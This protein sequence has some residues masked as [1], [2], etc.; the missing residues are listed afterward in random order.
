MIEIV[1]IYAELTESEYIRRHVDGGFVIEDP[2]G[3]LN[4]E[5]PIAEDIFSGV[6]EEYQLNANNYTMQL[7]TT[8]EGLNLLTIQEKTT[9]GNNAEGPLRMV[10]EVL[11]R[12]Q[13]R[14]S[15]LAVRHYLQMV[16]ATPTLAAQLLA[17]MRSNRNYNQMRTN[18]AILLTALLMNESEDSL[19]QMISRFAAQNI[20]SNMRANQIK[21]VY[22]ILTDITRIRKPQNVTIEQVPRYDGK[23]T[24]ER[25]TVSRFNVPSGTKRAVH[26]WLAN[27]SESDMDYLWLNYKR[28]LRS[29]VFGTQ[30]PLR[31]NAY[32][33]LQ[34]LVNEEHAEGSLFH[35]LKNFDKLNEDERYEFIIE[36]RIP[37]QVVLSKLSGNLQLTDW[38]ATLAV[39]TPN[40]LRRFH[41]SMERMGIFEV[42][43]LK[44][45]YD[46]R[47]TKTEDRVGLA[48]QMALAEATNNNEVKAS[49]VASV[50]RKVKS[51]AIDGDIVL[52]VDV[53]GSLTQG[54]AA[55]VRIAPVLITQAEAGAGSCTTLVYNTGCA[56]VTGNSMNAFKMNLAAITPRGGTEWTSCWNYMM[57]NGLTPDVVFVITDQG[58]QRHYQ[59]ITRAI[60]M[61]SEMHGYVPVI[62]ILN[63][64]N[65]TNCYETALKNAGLTEDSDYNVM[66][67]HD[68]RNVDMDQVVALASRGNIWQQTHAE[69]EEID[70]SQLM[71]PQHY[72]LVLRAM[73]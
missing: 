17:Y 31:E 60:Q 53:S 16:N 69:I 68:L 61:F 11:T 49:V 28:I 57:S 32:T 3:W 52:C 13:H 59:K 26:V 58:E 54:K 14:S 39:A 36:N 46:E 9:Y 43:E 6:A 33:Y 38:A 22:Q 44:S 24:V 29:I 37:Y 15:P 8:A 48:T 72:D 12:V 45:L 35:T 73:G 62:N 40:E 1:R 51:Q 71:A 21:L 66:N 23:G 63:V 41:N 20:L 18:Q 42:A 65:S 19:G 70:I 67:A 25:V 10:K 55:S 30:T 5:V 2:A 50:E 7:G 4:I 47:M 34:A 56:L 27:L 64:G